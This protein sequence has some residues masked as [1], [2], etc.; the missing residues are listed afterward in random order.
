MLLREWR[1]KNKKSKVWL[2]IH[3]GISTQ[4]VDKIESQGLRGAKRIHQIE[5]VTGGKVKAKD[6]MGGNK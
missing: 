5:R 2:A 3:L 1:E 6:L 4:A